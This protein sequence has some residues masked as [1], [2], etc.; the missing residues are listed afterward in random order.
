MIL[1]DDVVE[2]FD[3]ADFYHRTM[4]LVVTL[5]G[6]F[7]GVAPVNGDRLR[8]PVPANGLLEK[9]EG[10][11][12]VSVFCEQKV[13]SLSV[14]IHRTIQIPPLAFHADVRFIHPPAAP[15]RPLAA[16]ERLFEL[17]AVPEDPPVDGRVIH[18]D[19]TFAHEFFDV[20][21][22][23]GVGDL[24]ADACQNNIL[25]E[26]RPLEAHGHRLSPSVFTLSHRGRS[27]PKLT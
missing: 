10:G 7:I 12:L 26:M 3:L 27:Y 22:A 20:A 19:P 16:V 14:R 21:R 23:Q 18:V 15:H 5:D 9:P 24:P 25:R 17:R 8:D 11:R 13:N 2:I 1:F 4:F 6:G